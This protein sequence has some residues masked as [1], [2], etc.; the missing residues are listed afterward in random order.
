M[1]TSHTHT[2]TPTCISDQ[3]ASHLFFNSSTKP[4]NPVPATKHV[5]ASGTVQSS[6]P[7]SPVPCSTGVIAQPTAEH[8]P[9]SALANGVSLGSATGMLNA[10]P[11]VEA[12]QEGLNLST[13]KK[14]KR[15]NYEIENKELTRQVTELKSELE[16]SRK[17]L[18]ERNTQVTEL[19]SELEKSRKQLHERN[20]QV[21]ELKSELETSRKQLHERNTWVS[22]LEKR[23]ANYE[24]EINVLEMKIEQLEEL[25]KG[26][27]CMMCRYPAFAKERS[28]KRVGYALL[29]I[30]TF[31]DGPRD[32]QELKRA[33]L[34]AIILESILK[35]MG[36]KVK[37][38]FD[39]TEEE[40][41][42][43][44][45]EVEEELE[46]N[47]QIVLVYISTHGGLSVSGEKDSSDEESGD[48]EKQP[49]K[50]HPKSI[51][52]FIRD[53]NGHKI[54]DLEG[55]LDKYL[56]NCRGKLKLICVD[57]CRGEKCH[58]PN[59]TLP[60]N[61]IILR[62]CMSGYASHWCS[63]GSPMNIAFCGELLGAHRS[64]GIFTILQRVIAR[65]SEQ[66]LCYRNEDGKSVEVKQLPE[67][68]ST[69][70]QHKRRMRR[71][72]SWHGSTDVS[73]F[74]SMCII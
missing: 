5:L 2:H 7:V 65:V 61:R 51:G 42:R 73:C 55:V 27:S 64:D 50:K 16:K 53:K 39:T 24:K 26:A 18:H 37:L 66:M 33:K 30:N 21:T 34:D 45:S 41:Y 60:N 13:K 43:A 6:L 52:E 49:K 23:V 56:G 14:K 40:M 29:L 44:L 11:P 70:V 35:N 59:D 46:D 48:D 54:F 12:E 72:N 8:T 25:M 32:L 19:K 10:D 20:T 68:K 58:R 47:D 15:P 17:Q 9:D 62:S 71:R 69:D 57:A 36:F 3:A 28:G 31:S 74:K 22:E 63:Y 1:G 67:M 38:M 4:H